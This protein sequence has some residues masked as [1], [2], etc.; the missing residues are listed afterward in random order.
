MKSTMS[1]ARHLAT[2]VKNEPPSSNPPRSTLDVDHPRELLYAV[3]QDIALFNGVLVLVVFRVGPVGL[4]YTSHLIHLGV[5]PPQV[6]KA[7]QFPGTME[8]GGLAARRRPAG[9]D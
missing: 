7:C 3:E 9:K 4:H 8:R 6:D 2:D 5:Q 1:P